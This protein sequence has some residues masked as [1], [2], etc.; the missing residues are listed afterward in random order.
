MLRIIYLI[1]LRA[2]FAHIHLSMSREGE[3]K[4]EVLYPEYS[5][6]QRVG[7]PTSARERSQ[8]TAQLAVGVWLK[9]PSAAPTS[10]AHCQ[11]NKRTHERYNI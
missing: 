7:Q 5:G 10:V 2:L 3:T 8:P 4:T 9:A 11:L 1:S 6:R